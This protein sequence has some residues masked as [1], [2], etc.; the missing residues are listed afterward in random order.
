MTVWKLEGS[1]LIT[2]Y[3]AGEP[4]RHILLHFSVSRESAKL[5]A[6]EL[7]R[8]FALGYAAGKEDGL[9]EGFANGYH[10]DENLAKATSVGKKG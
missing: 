2:L 6:D 8:T 3:V 9:D 10:Y 7:N 5:I 4:T 1:G